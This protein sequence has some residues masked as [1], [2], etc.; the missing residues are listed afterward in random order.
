MTDTAAAPAPAAATDEAGLADLQLKYQARTAASPPNSSTS[1]SREYPRTI[2]LGFTCT[3]PGCNK[4]F[5][6]DVVF[7]APRR[8]MGTKPSICPECVHRDERR[9]KE[10]QQH[11]AEALSKPAVE[12]LDLR[13]SMRRAGGNPN[14][15]AKWD[16]HTFQPLPFQ[17]K[18]A[19]VTREFLQ[20]VLQCG[21]YDEMQG[22]YVCGPN[23]VGKTAV[24]QMLLR[25]ALEAGLRPGPGVIYD[26]AETL[27]MRIQD[28]YNARASA[29]E[30][31][32]RRIRTRL[33][34]VDELGA[35][36]P[37]DDA[38]RKLT[39]I[40]NEREGRPVYSLGN[41]GVNEL[42]QRHP[43]L[44]RLRARLSGYRLLFVDGPNLHN[45]ANRPRV[46]PPTVDEG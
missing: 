44:F 3:R 12:A 40:F 45:P 9:R 35:E 43:E 39:T 23:G 34:I 14:R 41:Y 46:A 15:Y 11:Q 30:F 28:T 21:K 20:A 22:V 32:E 38:A 1:G 17:E 36:R 8:R 25:A 7:F 4:P 26:S 13:A 16:L 33:W 29:W 10:Y 24:A 42:T 2:N 31:I 37:S 27:I 18:L 5:R 19:R 6:A